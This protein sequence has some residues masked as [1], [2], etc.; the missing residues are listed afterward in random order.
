LEYKQDGCI[1][2]QVDFSRRLPI[3]SFLWF[4][5]LINIIVA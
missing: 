4:D 3:D 2:S 1:K 5:I